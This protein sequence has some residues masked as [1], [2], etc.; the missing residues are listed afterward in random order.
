MHTKFVRKTLLRKLLFGRFTKRIRQK[1]NAYKVCKRIRIRQKE[2]AYKVCAENT[3]TKTA[4]WKI[5]EKNKT[6][7]K[8][9][10]S[11]C[12]K[13]FYENCYLEDCRRII[14]G[15]VSRK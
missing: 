5:Y 14:L 10:Q 9:I 7:R 6:E 15:G 13:H 4:I 11:L 12:G 2:N 3:F 8:C 1:E